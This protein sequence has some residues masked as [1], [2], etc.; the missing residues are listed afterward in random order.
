MRLSASFYDKTYMTSLSE[1]T[2]SGVA[3]SIHRLC[4]SLFR[5][6]TLSYHLMKGKTQDFL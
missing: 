4:M 6:K 5:Y 3:S 2:A 1:G